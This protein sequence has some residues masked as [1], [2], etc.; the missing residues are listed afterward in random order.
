MKNTV[1]NNTVSVT[2]EA[3]KHYED[4]GTEYWFARELMP[5]LEYDTW[6]SFGNTVIRAMEACRNAGESVKDCFAEVDKPIKSGKGG[7]QYIKDYKLNRYACYLIG[8]NGDPRK[9]VIAEAQ[10]YFAIQTRRQEI[11]IESKS[12]LERLTA[13]HKLSET[14]KKFAAVLFEHDVDKKNLAIIKSEGDKAL[15]GGRSTQDMKDKL[16]IKPDK[17]LADFLPTITIKAKDL[18]AE[19]TT[20]KTKENDL[21]GSSIIKD[22]HIGHNESVREALKKEGIFPE[23]LPAEEDIK[24]VERKLTNP[25]HNKKPID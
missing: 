13:R 25:K 14:E 9:R 19:M 17:P 18:A 16:K 20:F 5:L 22:T 10:T 7:I 12:Q 15:F 24:K 11:Q 8:Q 2:F 23:N 1:I 21:K 3:I 6:R 4:D